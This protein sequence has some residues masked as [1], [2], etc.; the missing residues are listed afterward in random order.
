MS[1]IP[2][3]ISSKQSEFSIER[4]V[5]ADQIK[6]FTPLR[7]II[8]EEWPPQAT[9]VRDAMLERVRLAPVYIGLFASVYSEPTEI[10]YREAIKNPYREIL[11][12]VQRRVPEERDPRLQA[13][14]TE[15]NDRHVVYQFN[16]LRDL[17]EVFRDHLQAVIIRMITNLQKLGENKPVGRGLHSPLLNRWQ[18][19]QDALAAFSWGKMELDN[20]LQILAKLQLLA[21]DQALAKTK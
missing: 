20:R 21:V 7:P 4:A 2:V 13:L 5:L 14:I 18:A 12:Y 19:E 16:D 1:H 8:A 6:A 11:I 17:L 3:F 15:F 9:A 10:E